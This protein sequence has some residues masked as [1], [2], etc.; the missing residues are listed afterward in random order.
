MLQSKNSANK[1]EINDIL[2]YNDI[3]NLKPCIVQIHLLPVDGGNA[4][5]GFSSN[6]IKQV[7]DDKRTIYV[8]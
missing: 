7:E 6:S 5:E 4:P 2:R 3:L 1:V 8:W